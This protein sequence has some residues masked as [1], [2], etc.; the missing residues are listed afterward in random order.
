MPPQTKGNMRR[1]Y[2]RDEDVTALNAIT[3]ALEISQ[4]EVMGRIMAAGIRAIKDAGNRMPL[5]LSFEV[6]DANAPWRMNESKP[7]LPHKRK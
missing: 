7:P 5:P 1:L 6:V 2:L 4:T 3:E